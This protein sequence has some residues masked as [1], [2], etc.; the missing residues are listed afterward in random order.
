MFSQL[1]VHLSKSPVSFD[2]NRGKCTLYLSVCKSHARTQKEMTS[3]LTR[4]LW[5]HKCLPVQLVLSGTFLKNLFRV[6]STGKEAAIKLNA[7]KLAG[8]HDRIGL[9]QL[10]LSIG[11]VVKLTVVLVGIPVSCTVEEFAPTLETS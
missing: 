7:A 11:F 9:L 8:F 5:L 6:S 1:L 10:I 2:E 4:E 3:N